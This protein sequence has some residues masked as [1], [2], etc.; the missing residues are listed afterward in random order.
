MLSFHTFFGLFFTLLNFC[1][2]FSIS[3]F[4]LALMSAHMKSYSQPYRQG[5]YISPI[6]LFSVTLHL[7]GKFETHSIVLKESRRLLAGITNG[8]DVVVATTLMLFF[9]DFCAFAVLKWA[10]R[11]GA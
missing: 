5:E 1:L 4:S 10:L 11:T 3:V 2:A 6:N 9:A 8:R 7:C